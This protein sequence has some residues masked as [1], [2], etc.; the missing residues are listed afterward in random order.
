MQ[1]VLVLFAAFVLASAQEP[2]PCESPRQWEAR[3]FAYERGSVREEEGKITYDEAY[4]RVRFLVRDTVNDQTIDAYEILILHDKGVEYRND[5]T[6]NQCTQRQITRPFRPFGVPPNA[7]S[8]GL[9]Y[10]GT[11]AFPGAGMEVSVWG[12]EVREDER[13]ETTVTAD[14]C[15]PV[16]DIFFSREEGSFRERVTDF[17]DIVAP[18]PDSSV[19]DVPSECL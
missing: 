9:Y 18:Y 10:I 19:F 17:Y 7:T 5:F 4:Q 11:S 16:S 6:T 3:Y 15:I 14:A 13:F 1:F 8:Y 2:K 12:G